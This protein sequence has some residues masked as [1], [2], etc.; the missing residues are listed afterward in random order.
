MTPEQ[1]HN[2]IRE[3]IIAAVPEIVELKFGCCI[4]DFMRGQAVIIDV[5]HHEGESDTYTQYYDKIPKPEVY[6]S[7]FH[8]WEIIGR[9]IRI[10]DILFAIGKTDC[11]KHKAF[12]H[13]AVSM[14]G[15]FYNA[16]EKS[17]KV[18]ATYNLRKDSLAD[19]PQCWDFLHSILC[20]WSLKIR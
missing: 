15:E 1:K 14:Y 3:K 9:E 4:E 18:L 5:Q 19:N 17:G 20:V 13:L 10:A 2:E 7:P 8:N 16:D 6:Q 12:N 11:P